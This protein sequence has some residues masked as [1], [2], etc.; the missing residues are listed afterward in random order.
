MISLHDDF[1][2]QAVFQTLQNIVMSERMP[3][4]CT[5]T[6]HDNDSDNSFEHVVSNDQVFYIAALEIANTFNLDIN[7]LNR[8]RCGLIT[9]DKEYTVHTP[10]IDLQIPH[11]TA[12]LYLNDSDGETF[13]YDEEASYENPIGNPNS[14]I[15]MAV[16]PK[17]NKLAFFDGRVYHSS[18]TP[19]TN[20]LRY[21]VNFNF[22]V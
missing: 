6:S 14:K 21:A 13:F 16:K 12:L 8:I 3:W 20:K 19:V 5:K 1:I 17:E 11:V 2:S 10:H 7:K 4:F 9:R 15:I 18:S 22:E